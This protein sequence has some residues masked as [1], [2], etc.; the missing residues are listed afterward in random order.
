M[1]ERALAHDLNG[2]A[3][4][5]FEPVGLVCTIRAPLEF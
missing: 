2:S 4:L 5:D 1:I 3:K